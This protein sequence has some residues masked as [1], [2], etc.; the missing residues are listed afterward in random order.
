MSNDRPDLSLKCKLIVNDSSPSQYGT[1]C[2]TCHGMNGR[3]PNDAGRWMYPRVADLTS[4]EV[5]SYADR[6]L[7][8]MV[9]NDIRLSGMPAYARSLNPYSGGNASLSKNDPESL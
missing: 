9:R 5:H 1:E 2:A 3:V 4:L 7:F 8:W 6:E